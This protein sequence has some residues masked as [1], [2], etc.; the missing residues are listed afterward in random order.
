MVRQSLDPNPSTRVHRAVDVRRRHPE[1]DAVKTEDLA[2]ALTNER[3]E[4][5]QRRIRLLVL[6]SAAE[7]AGLVPLRILRLHSFAYLS[8]V[9]APVWD[10]PALDGKVLKRHGGPFYPALQRDLD[11]LVGMGRVLIR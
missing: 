9:L 3:I 8:N 2:A 5:L 4:E 7:R 10:M 11:R 1:R 6:L